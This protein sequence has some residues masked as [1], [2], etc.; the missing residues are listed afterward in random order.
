MSSIG[1]PFDPVI[2]TRRRKMGIKF[3]D[4]FGRRPVVG[5]STTEIDLALNLVCGQV[6]RAIFIKI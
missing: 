1:I 3:F 5:F 4:H 6:R 2:D